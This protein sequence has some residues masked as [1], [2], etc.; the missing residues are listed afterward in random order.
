VRATGAGGQRDED[1]RRRQPDDLLHRE[2]VLRVGER[3]QEGHRHAVQPVLGDERG[4]GS[5]GLALVQPDHD[6]PGGIHPFVQF[7]H[8]PG[9]DQ[10]G[11][12]RRA[13]DPEHVLHPAPRH[14]AVPAHDGQGIPVPGR[15]DH[16][17]PGA[18]PLQH[19]VGA[20]RGP[21]PEPLRLAQQPGQPQAGPFGQLGEPGHHP[22]GRITL[23]G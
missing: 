22:V 13:A 15:R 12:Q 6:L 16:P 4:D 10:R 2:L 14:P 18:G 9:H 8:R 17:D 20:D 5:P 11:G 1:V 7:Q 21:V 19:R 23:G 3:P